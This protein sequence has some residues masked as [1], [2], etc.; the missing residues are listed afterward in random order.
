MRRWIA[1]ALLLVCCLF[2]VTA[3]AETE[4]QALCDDLLG[5]A[6]ETMA[7]D[8]N[9]NAKDMDMD[10]ASMIFDLDKERV[11]ASDAQFYCTVEGITQ[12]QNLT[13]FYYCLKHYN[14]LESAALQA[15]DKLY[16]ILNIDSEDKERGQLGVTS[17]NVGGVMEATRALLIKA[18]VAEDDPL[19][20]GAATDGATEAPVVDMGKGGDSAALPSAYQG[21]DWLDVPLTLTDAVLVEGDDLAQLREDFEAPEA[22]FLTLSFTSP[23]GDIPRTAYDTYASLIKLCDRAGALTSLCQRSAYM[24]NLEDGHSS[25]D[26]CRTMAVTFRLPV[27]AALNDYVIFVPGEDDAVLLSY[28]ATFAVP[29][30]RLRWDG[31]LLWLSSHND[32]ASLD[33]DDR[34]NLEPGETFLELVVYSCKTA[35]FTDENIDKRIKLEGR[36]GEVY[37]IRHSV[38]YQRDSYVMDGEDRINGIRLVF[39]VPETGDAADYVL[40]VP[41]GDTPNTV[42]V[43]AE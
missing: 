14:E 18:G 10:Y 25:D 13:L 22:Q 15:S 9:V 42:P 3:C 29:D 16:I 19:F 24:D 41:D 33:E 1:L 43:V 5:A 8:F 4:F 27:N 26:Y 39:Y 7:L 11:V 40:T 34:E 32:G 23:D 21:F 12:R 17:E 6:C 30:R 38:V 2:T 35:M 28:G 37:G 36:D 20:Y 31:N